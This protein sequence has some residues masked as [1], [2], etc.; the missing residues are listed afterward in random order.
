VVFEELS[1]V[2]LGLLDRLVFK[3][4][5][6]EGLVCVSQVKKLTILLIFI[7]SGNKKVTLH[8][9]AFTT[10]MRP[11]HKTNRAF[12]SEVLD[13]DNIVPASRVENIWVCRVKNE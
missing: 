11:S 6:L 8:I 7:T 9:Y 13:V 4:D 1:C 3:L 5:L 2:K 12:I 10:D